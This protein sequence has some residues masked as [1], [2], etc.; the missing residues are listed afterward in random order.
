[1]NRELIYR[2]GK[3]AFDIA[4]SGVGLVLTSPVFLASAIGIELSDPGPVFYLA[5]RAGKDNKPFRML[6]FRSMRI[7][8]SADEKSLRPDQNRI[9]PYGRFMRNTKIDELPQ[10]L[11]VLIGSMTVVGPRPAAMDQIEITR[12]GENAA[13]SALKPGLTSPSALYDYIYGDRIEDE[14]EYNEKVLPTRLAL[15]LFYLRKQGFGYD[16]RMVW[17]TLRCV[18]GSVTGNPPLAI[19]EELI[20]AVDGDQST[21]DEVRES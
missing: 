5:K 4:A 14:E 11:N 8:R 20:K 13:A 19:L 15:D 12:G 9:F 18:L 17:Y 6:K 21:L 16:M 2:A 7:D 10:L 1:M 3:R